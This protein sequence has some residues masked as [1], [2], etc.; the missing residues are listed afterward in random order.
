MGFT[1]LVSRYQLARSEGLVL[2]Y[3]TDA[4]KTLRQTVG[5]HRRTE[6]LEDLVAWLGETIRQ[7][8]SSLLDE[9]EALNDPAHVPGAVAH[10]EPPPP[11]RPLSR[12]ARAFGVMV[13]NAMWARVAL[14]A[15]DDLDGLVRLEREA[16]DRVEPARAVVMGRS[17]WDSALEDYYSEHDEVLTD[18]DARGPSLLVVGEER[19][20]RPVGADEE[21]TARVRDVRQTLHD[22]EGHHDW[23]VEAIVDCDATDEAGALVLAVAAMRRL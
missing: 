10:H 11:P 14:V 20:G 22:P 6:E 19:Q 12:Q 9:W 4:Y 15:R 17:A 3:L 16:A 8:D 1:D 5:E 7:V 23:V 2:R 13:R 21:V 18:A